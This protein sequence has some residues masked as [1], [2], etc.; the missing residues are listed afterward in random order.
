M[1][2]KRFFVI[3]VLMAVMFLLV[4]SCGP[5]TDD[6]DAIVEEPQYGGIFKVAYGSNPASM[7]MHSVTGQVILETAG[8]M[9]ER[10]F[11]D[12]ADLIPRPFLVESYTVS[13]DG[14]TYVFKLKEGVLFHNGK[15]MTAEDVVASIIRTNNNSPSPTILG[16]YI[17]S[18]EAVDKYSVEFRFSEPLSDVEARLSSNTYYVIYPKELCEKYPD[19]RIPNEEV[20][21]T[22]PYKFGE[23]RSDQFLRFEK[24]EDYHHYGEEVG[25]WASKRYAYVDEIIFHIIPDLAVR[26]LGV[27]TGEYDFCQSI[28]FGD[29]DRFDENPNT[30]PH[31]LTNRGY[32]QAAINHTA[33]PV[34]DLQVRKAAQ[35]AAFGQ[36][37]AEFM[38]IKEELWKPAINCAFLQ[39]GEYYTEAGCEYYN[40]ND[41][42]KAR[43]ILEESDY[44]GTPVVVIGM[45][46]FETLKNCAIIFANQLEEAGF[47]VELLMSDQGTWI[48]RY[49]NPDGGWHFAVF[50]NT[51]PP[52]TP[53]FPWMRTEAIGWWTAQDNRNVELG[54]M[55]RYETDPQKRFQLWEK[56]QQLVYEE[57]GVIKFCEF[58]G[59]GV[60]GAKV[61]GLHPYG[62]V[63][64]NVWFAE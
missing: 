34:S 19:G 44:D 5:V 59:G 1:L 48:S 21:G 57:V 12:C 55:I 29:W 33:W 63:F 20:V 16:Q 37:M 30:Q 49:I 17:A 62:H 54:D 53:E 25:G 35:A 40:M 18:L 52:R 42:E 4:S 45:T 6:D 7:D 2:D 9:A 60:A 47:E 51:A 32:M 58:Y 50:A 22:G 36:P 39:S 31:I 26:N 41:P 3:A 46:E 64:W 8:H 27:E 38:F 56:A 11:E 28:E 23:F 61:R 15:E 14:L 10:L 43:Q 13:D 24:F